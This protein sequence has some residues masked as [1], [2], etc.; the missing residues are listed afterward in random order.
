MSRHV[1]LPWDNPELRLQLSK[2]LDVQ[3]LAIAA[4]VCKSWN[5]TFSSVLYSRVVWTT[6]KLSP[7]AVISNRHHIKLLNIQRVTQDFPFDG[8]K[9]LE[10]LRIR[11]EVQEGC[12]L[13]QV[14]KLFSQSLKLRRVS[15]DI[16]GGQNGFGI[17]HALS[18]C[19]SLEVLWVRASQLSVLT[20]NCLFSICPRLRDLTLEIGTFAGTQSITRLEDLPHITSLNLSIESGL[21]CLQQLKVIERCPCLHKL[22]WAVIFEDLPCGEFCKVL[23]ELSIQEL[24]LKNISKENKGSTHDAALSQIIESCRNLTIFST[25]DIPF[26][27]ASFQSLRPHFPGLRMLHLEGS[28]T[29]SNLALEILVSCP[30]LISLVVPV[31]M[32]SD[33]R[34][35][36]LKVVY[37]VLIPNSFR[38]WSCLNI[39]RLSV[40]ICVVRKAKVEYHK[41]A[42]AQLSELKNLVILDIEPKNEQ[43]NTLS[44]FSGLDLR[45]YSGL[46]QL[47]TLKKLE[48]LLFTGVKQSMGIKDVKWMIQAWPRLRNFHGTGST[49]RYTNKRLNDI[50]TRHGISNLDSNNMDDGGDAH[51]ILHVNDSEDSDGGD[52][53]SGYDDLESDRD[54][55]EGGYDEYDEYDERGYGD[56]DDD[57]DFNYTDYNMYYDHRYDSDYNEDNDYFY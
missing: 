19:Q 8:L 56:D 37:G 2:Y 25:L 5:D 10:V 27:E 48:S 53:A 50:L 1:N 24:N 15:L 35:Q 57:D 55:P 42:F 34:K 16:P 54:D 49:F 9:N 17:V 36:P 21:S 45:L 41:S 7:K 20:V 44:V 12:T 39:T 40:Y 4:A 38:A 18:Q 29:P 52:R 26:G 11:C 32:H 14:P 33:F 51:D 43:L 47:E 30:M 13:N 3:Q 31:L 22:S 6:E 23:S 28:S 46:G